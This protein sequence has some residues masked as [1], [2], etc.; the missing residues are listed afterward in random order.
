MPYAR[1]LPALAGWAALG[2]V[3]LPA[4]VRVPVT[5]AFLL[6]G[7]GMALTGLTARRRTRLET[8]VLALTVSLAVDTLVAVALHLGGWFTPARAVLVLAVLTTLAVLLRRPFG[9]AGAGAAALV[10]LSGCGTGTGHE[11]WNTPGAQASPTGPPSLDAPAAPGD[12]RLVFQDEFD[13]AR[14]DGARWATCYD[15]NDRGCTNRGNRELEWYL[16]GQVTQ[17][18]GVLA[19][20]ADRRA[21]TGSDGQ[22]YPWASGMVSTGRDSWDATPRRTFTRGYFAAAIRVPPQA[23]M[24]PAFWLMPATR[25]T[26]PELDVVEFI[27]DPHDAQLT[28]HWA[29][30]DGSDR[31]E[32]VHVGPA[33][34]PGG[35]HVFALAWEQSSLTWYIDGVARHRETDPTRIPDQPMELL[36]NLAVGYPTAPPDGVDTAR[37]EVDWVRVWQH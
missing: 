36:L 33:D 1:L 31:H 18:Q 12:W 35:F 5:L 15:W 34:Y 4:P 22:R 6:A 25:Q 9:R 37:L 7:P 13:G 30:P 27:S 26:P 16:P 32:A 23:G 29:G 2:A 28:V 17:G 21:T 8:A 14:L 24:F 3:A 10:L 11:V 20:T 19:L